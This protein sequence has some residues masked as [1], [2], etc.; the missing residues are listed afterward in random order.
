MTTINYE[1]KAKSLNSRIYRL[2]WTV[3]SLLAIRWRPR[4]MGM[5][6][7]KFIYRLFGANVSRQAYLYNSASVYDPRNLI[8]EG[9]CELGPN[10]EIYNVNVVKLEDG[11]R[12]SQNSYLCTAGHDI[13]VITPLMPLTSAPI[14][15][16]KNAWVA[17]SAFVGPGVTIGEGAVVGAR[18][19]V[20][21]DV[22]PWTVVGG[23]PAKVLKKRMIIEKNIK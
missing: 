10:T 17:A 22:E 15:I 21:K 14:T 20:F 3:I 13:S 1:E 19:V 5:G 6:V 4:R 9:G 18:G 8:L 11:A 16:K 7:T 2:V 12:I 23:N